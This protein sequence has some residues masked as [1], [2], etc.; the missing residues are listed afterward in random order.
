MTNENL[1]GFFSL[2]VSMP[3]LAFL[4][5]LS[6]LKV[7]LNLSICCVLIYTHP[8]VQILASHFFLPHLFFLLPVR[9]IS[10]GQGP[11]SS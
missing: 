8:F 6:L 2:F 9:Y 7:Y 10:C 3:K 11:N 4:L 1:K 5:S